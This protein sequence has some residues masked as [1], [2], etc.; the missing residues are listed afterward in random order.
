MTRD[1]STSRAWVAALLTIFPL[2]LTCVA[3]F[4]NAV[5][6]ANGWSQIAAPGVARRQWPPSPCA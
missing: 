6:I 1:A 4:M 2:A 3:L 5:A